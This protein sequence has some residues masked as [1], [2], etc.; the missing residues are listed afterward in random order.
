MQELM[1]LAAAVAAL[2][3]TPETSPQPREHA[4]IA[5]TA[6]PAPIFAFG[7]RMPRVPRPHVP[8]PGR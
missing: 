1:S 7:F 5:R 6:A 2:L 8:W 4:A 3:G